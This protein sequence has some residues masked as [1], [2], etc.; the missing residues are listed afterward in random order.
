MPNDNHLS[1]AFSALKEAK[2]LFSDTGYNIGIMGSEGWQA[3]IEGFMKEKE[4]DFEKA[5]ALYTKSMKIFQR[6]INEYPQTKETVEGWALFAM[7]GI[8]STKTSVTITSLESIKKEST[9]IADFLLRASAEDKNP[10]FQNLYRGNASMIIA[11]ARIV[12]ADELVDSWRIKDS[13]R[14]VEGAEKKLKCRDT[15]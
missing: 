7:R 12:E 8:I 10:D 4:D 1:D 2:K 11:M 14:L 13:K 6:I 3:L 15:L 9:D 5:N